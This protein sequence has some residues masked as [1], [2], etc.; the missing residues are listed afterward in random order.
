ML[1]RFFFILVSFFSFAWCAGPEAFNRDND[2]LIN[3]HV[4]VMTGKLQLNFVDHVVR[5]AVPL[6]LQRS[7]SNYDSTKLEHA[8]WQFTED[9]SFFSHTHLYTE[10]DTAEIVESSGQKVTYQKGERIRD[11]FVYKPVMNPEQRSDA[12]TFRSN[13]ANNRLVFDTKKKTAKL[14][15]CNGGNRIYR[16]LPKR[17]RDKIN[18]F[19]SGIYYEYLL[20]EEISPSGQRTIYTYCDVSKSIR[21][22]QKN[23]CRTKTFASAWIRQVDDYPNFKIVAITSDGS[24]LEYKGQAIASRCH[25]DQLSKPGWPVEKY[26]YKLNKK[27]IKCWMEAIAVNGRDSL[28]VKHHPKTGVVE[29]I[30]EGGQKVATYVHHPK[31]TEVKDCNG[32]ITR[33]FYEYGGLSAVEYCDQEGKTLSSEKFIWEESNLIAKVICDGNGRGVSSRTFVYDKDKNVIQETLYGNISGDR[34]DAFTV[35]DKGVLEGAD[36]YSKWYKYNKGYL[37]EQ[38]KE[39]NGVISIYKYLTTTDVRQVKWT[40]KDKDILSR[41][42][43]DF[44]HDLLPNKKSII[45]G[46]IEKTELYTRDPTT[47]MITEIDDGLTKITYTYNQNKQCIVESNGKASISTEY[48]VAGRVVCKTFPCG[49]KN[50]YVYDQLGNPIKI[51]R[52]GEPWKTI[53]YDSFNRPIACEVEGRRSTSAYDKQG[54]IICEVDYKG[55]VTLFEYNFLGQC[56]KKTL[57]YLEDENGETYTPEY[58]YEYDLQGNVIYEKTPSGGVTRHG[59]NVLGKLI[60]TIFPD[61]SRLTNRYFLDGSLKET[62]DPSGIKTTYEYEGNQ[63]L[64]CKRRNALE[65]RWEYIGRLIKKYTSELGVVTTYEYD[66]HGR[67]ILENCEG[68]LLHFRYDELGYIHEVDDGEL[69]QRKVHDLEGRVVE[70]SENN[71]NRTWYDYDEE[72]RKTRAITE[73]SAGEAIDR[74]FYDATGRIVLHINPLEQK[75]E[76]FY[77]DYARTIVDAAGNRS[78]ERFD[79]HYRLIEKEKQSPSEETLFLENFFYDRAGNVVRRHIHGQ[80]MDVTYRFDQMGRVLEEVEAGVKVTSFTYDSRGL[81]SEKTNPD[82][83]F[84]TYQYDDLNRMTAMKS[85]DRTV[86]YEYIYNGVHLHEIKDHIF[87]LSV[88]Y[89]YTKFGQIAE[90]TGFLGFKTSWY[91]DMY[92]RT[93][94]VTLPD[95][96]FI[97]YTYENSLMH[98]VIRFNKEGKLL[99]EH[100]YA[101]Y[102][103]AK[104]VTEEFFVQDIGSM[105]TRRDLLQRPCQVDSDFH[106]QTVRYGATGLVT[107]NKNSLTKET[108][109]SYDGLN[110]LTEEGEISYEFDSLGNPKEYEIDNLNQIVST[111][112]ESF[113][114][115]LN[116]NMTGRGLIQYGYDA[117]HRLTLIAYSNGKKIAFVY[118]P[119]SR[120]V[121]KRTLQN[122]KLEHEKFYLYD[123]EFE[124]GTMNTRGEVE[125]LKVLGL[126]VKGDIGAAIAIE[127][128]G[129]VFAPI[130]DVQGN[131]TAIL[132]ASKEVVEKYEYNAFGEEKRVNYKNPWR[133]ASKRAEEGLV[134]FGLR[135]YDPGLKRWISP[136]PLGFAE[137]RNVYLYVLNDPVNRLDLFGLE[138]TYNMKLPLNMAV[139]QNANSANQYYGWFGELPEPFITFGQ[140]EFNNDSTFIRLQFAANAKF[141]FSQKEMNQGYFNFFE[142][143]HEVIAGCEDRCAYISSMNGINHSLKN[144]SDMGEGICAKL[145]STTLV[146]N[147]YNKTI[148]VVAD[149][150]RA[151]LEYCGY[152]TKSIRILKC[153]NATMAEIMEKHTPNAHGLHIA[154]SEAG[155]IYAR[156][157]EKSTKEEQKKMRKFIG[158]LGVGSARPIKDEYTKFSLNMYSRRD[159]VTGFAGLLLYRGC[160]IEWYDSISTSDQKMFGIIDHAFLGN[161]YSRGLD[162]FIDQCKREYGGFHEN[163]QR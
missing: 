5:G 87:G 59:Y 144:F 45:E 158:V 143:I 22:E 88:R 147:L 57:P 104:H 14:Y 109:Y 2:P 132:N 40:V 63:Q 99:Y 152:I 52:V 160:N 129:E 29:E 44:N 38:E 108:S 37:L 127:I 161:T 125:E 54:R 106:G 61:G 68:K 77:E 39:E 159:F 55:A 138:S 134:F 157:Y 56:I 85:S 47:G 3:H 43:F 72:N 100:L 6:T 21:I 51:K 32:Y 42:S 119:L 17:K 113:A 86:W 136:D 65:E 115:D 82:G 81:L 163:Y 34:A 13:P 110:Q 36:S 121:A 58:I 67:K 28:H 66:S 41:E 84:F 48:D 141:S 124:I 126:G 73:T 133:F 98:R 90:E 131:V 123:K 76:F 155:L 150:G 94:Q 15:L 137:S 146:M 33:Y 139:Y 9:W 89:C 24:C 83:V 25:L 148:N 95:Q 116:G 112:K 93:K 1:Q 30:I 35:T 120:L 62:V 102:D 117:L 103:G 97:Q 16:A 31:Y 145:P 8:K 4:N 75:T 71:F 128:K 50:E 105:S 96:S 130:H 26:S 162:D 7:Y 78:I 11:G 64:V 101:D 92:G 140:A 19:F 79:S 118:D 156:A 70:I 91:Y 49:G 153:F 151:G 149:A 60:Y 107:E 142:H 53:E 69:C 114:Y 135:F 18:I 111:P 27:P 154:H 20:A 122:G 74:F 12:M 10:G 23:F 46:G 80:D